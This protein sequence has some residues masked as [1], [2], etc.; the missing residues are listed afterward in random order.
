MKIIYLN[1]WNGE[2]RTALVDFISQQSKDTDI[3]CF[4]EFS[5]DIKAVSDKILSN[6]TSF[7]I[8]KDLLHDGVS[9]FE[10]TIYV[11]KNLN[12]ISHGTLL[13]DQ[14]DGGLAVY[15]KLMINDKSLYICNAHGISKPIEKQD[16]MGRLKQSNDLIGFFQDKAGAK[17]IGGD[18]NLLPITESIQMFEKNWYRNLVKEFNTETTRNHFAWDRYP[19]NKQYFAD[20]IFISK[21]ITLN[22]FEVSANEISDHLPLILE[23]TMQN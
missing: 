14:L 12:V 10:Q 5:E 23:F 1:A 13:D 6:Y 11:R 7:S 3:F 2:L 22:R 21:D 17:I 9:V 8:Y 20:Y 16:T 15:V 18:F 4:Q 19:D